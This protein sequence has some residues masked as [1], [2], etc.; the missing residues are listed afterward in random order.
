MSREHNN[1]NNNDYGTYNP[2]AEPEEWTPPIVRGRDQPFPPPRHRT[3][4]VQPAPPE[5]DA[6]PPPPPPPH[7]RIPRGRAIMVMSDHHGRQDVYFDQTLGEWRP[8]PRASQ[9]IITDE[10]WARFQSE[11]D[12]EEDGGKKKKKKKRDK[13]K[14]L[15]KELVLAVKDLAH[16]KEKKDKDDEERKARLLASISAPVGTTR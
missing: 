7:R 11:E 9:I 10:N 13:L 4:P 6:S 12:D 5:P 16:P 2:Y 3:Y 1:N 14:K 15:G 8:L